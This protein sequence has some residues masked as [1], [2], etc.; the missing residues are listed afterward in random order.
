MCPSPV[1]R[2]VSE[3]EGGREEC[4]ADGGAGPHGVLFP[5]SQV[6]ARREA[7]ES[8]DRKGCAL[9]EVPGSTDP[10]C[11]PLRVQRATC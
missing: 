11:C 8:E 7:M 2:W 4:A 6:G 1:P 3:G 9:L 10:T 5:G